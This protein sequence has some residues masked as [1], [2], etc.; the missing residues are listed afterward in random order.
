MLAPGALLLRTEGHT[1][2]T[3]FRN[4]RQLG[5]RGT[6]DSAHQGREHRGLEFLWAPRNP[7]EQKHLGAGG[8]QPPG[9]G[10]GPCRRVR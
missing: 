6:A 4:D 8:D 5:V 9:Q 1:V 3:V 2:G 10:G 7:E